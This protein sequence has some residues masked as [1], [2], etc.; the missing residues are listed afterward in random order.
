MVGGRGGGGHRGED[1]D[2]DVGH[3]VA[4]HRRGVGVTLLHL[5]RQDHVRLHSPPRR[6]P[7]RAMASAR[8]H[9]HRPQRDTR[10]PRASPRP[11]APLT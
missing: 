1:L 10:L 2:N 11:P 6:P 3:A 5:G 7:I 4:Q 8:E 9:T